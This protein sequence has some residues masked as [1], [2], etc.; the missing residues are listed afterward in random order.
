MPFDLSSF[1]SDDILKYKYSRKII[2]NFYNSVLEKIDYEDQF[3]IPLDEVYA[4]LDHHSGYHPVHYHHTCRI[5][6]RKSLQQKIAEV[7]SRSIEK[8]VIEVNG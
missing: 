4:D 7:L 1:G 3:I 8:K 6:L 2:A 5:T